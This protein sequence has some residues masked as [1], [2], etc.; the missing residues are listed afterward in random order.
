MFR[1]FV[2]AVLLVGLTL[3]SAFA[4]PQRQSRP[5]ND[6]PHKRGIF[7]QL[8]LTESQQTQMQKLR[9]QLMKK[10]S[11]LRSKV[12]TLRLDTKELFLAEKVDRSA[13][14]K[15]VKAIGDVQEQMK[16]TLVDHWFEVN[17]MLTP[18]QQL[19][20]KKHALVLGDQMREKMKTRGHKMMGE[21]FD[22]EF[23]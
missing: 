9:I 22:E 7:K 13:L 2:S 21:R 16:L 12:Q 4:Q 23:E 18:E 10:Q 17:T 1:G 3:T 6:S 14:E 15:N 19:V 5:Q 20:W 11:Q 8:N